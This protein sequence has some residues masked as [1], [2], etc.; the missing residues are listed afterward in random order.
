MRAHDGQRRDADLNQ[1]ETPPVYFRLPPFAHAAGEQ[2]DHD[3]AERRPAEGAETE[4]QQQ[5]VPA[6]ERRK[7]NATEDEGKQDEHG[8]FG[9]VQHGG[10]SAGPRREKQPAFS[11]LR[12]RHFDIAGRCADD[13]RTVSWYAMSLSPLLLPVDLDSVLAGQNRQG[14]LAIFRAHRLRAAVDLH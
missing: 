14:Q 8:E 11:W 7:A 3:D 1:V 12:Q 2:P 5:P 9:P 4:A 13:R 6:P 10:P